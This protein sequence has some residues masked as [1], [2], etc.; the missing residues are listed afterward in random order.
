MAAAESPGPEGPRGAAEA[1]AEADG[2]GLTDLPGELLE[3]ILCC[4]VLGAADIGRVSCTCRRLREAC[5]PRGKVWRERFRLRWAPPP[6]T[7]RHGPPGRAGEEGEGSPRVSSTA[8]GRAGPVRPGRAPPGGVQRG[9]C[10]RS[11]RPGRAGVRLGG[12]EMWK[13]TPHTTPS[14]PLLLP[15]PQG[16]CGTPPGCGRALRLSAVCLT[17]EEK[18]FP[19]RDGRGCCKACFPSEIP[20]DGTRLS[21]LLGAGRCPRPPARSGSVFVA[22]S[23]AR[24]LD[25]LQAPDPTWGLAVVWTQGHMHAGVVD[26][27]PFS[28]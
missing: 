6:L 1:E 25:Y 7:A 12:R 3:L 19:S 21:L 13:C 24:H 16:A 15:A 14:L 20:R 17:G 28:H 22:P 2:M 4:D 9:R 27:P 8:R 10:P 26:S 5:Q 23:A 18:P 11:P